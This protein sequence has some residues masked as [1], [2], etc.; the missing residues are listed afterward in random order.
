MIIRGRVRRRRSFDSHDESWAKADSHPNPTSRSTAEEIS[1]LFTDY[2]T[3]FYYMRILAICRMTPRHCSG[4][5]RDNRAN[6]PK[7]FD[8]GSGGA[9]RDSYCPASSSGLLPLHHLDLRK[10][11]FLLRSASLFNVPS[12]KPSSLRTIILI[13]QRT[14]SMA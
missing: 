2:P 1:A 11:K 4:R 3:I 5:N 6:R 13:S 12:S 8:Q 14:F 9:D 10:T 7:P